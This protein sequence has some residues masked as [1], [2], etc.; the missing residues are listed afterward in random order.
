[1]LSSCLSVM[2][3][4]ILILWMGNPW[5]KIFSKGITT[6]PASAT[7]K[8]LPGVMVGRRPSVRTPALDTDCDR[9]AARQPRCL[10]L[11]MLHASRNRG[12]CK[13]RSSA[14][15]FT[16]GMGPAARALSCTAC[17]LACSLPA[18]NPAF[19]A[20]QGFES[21]P[22]GPRHHVVSLRLANSKSGNWISLKVWKLSPMFK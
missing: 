15:H 16:D 4:G 17:H 21:D 10:A 7:A 14:E 1:M 2:P 22:S 19:L 9:S 20:C 11:R 5:S 12:K 18:G 13:N 8:M 3:G 6:R